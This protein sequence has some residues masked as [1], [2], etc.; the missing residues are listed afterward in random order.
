MHGLRRMPAFKT[1]LSDAQAEAL[2][3]HV[4]GLKR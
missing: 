3:A 1:K 2:V 4:R